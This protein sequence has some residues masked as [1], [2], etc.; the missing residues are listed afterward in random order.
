ME[1]KPKKHSVLRDIVACI[2]P[3]VSLAAAVGIAVL[4]FRRVD[5]S[6]TTAQAAL[7]EA[8][9]SEGQVVEQ[10]AVY[11]GVEDPWIAA[12]SFTVGDEELDAYIRDFCKECSP[13]GATA[14][15]AAQETFNVIVDSTYLYRIDKPMGLD[16][17]ARSAKEYFTS[18][19]GMGGHQGDV[20]EYASVLALCLRYFGY[21]DAIAVPTVNTSGV[22][23]ADGSALCLVTNTDGTGC[24]C[25]PA[26]GSAGWMLPRTSYDILVDDI[27][28]NKDA[29][30]AMGLQIK[31]KYA[32]DEDG[33]MN[34]MDDDGTMGGTGTTGTYG[35]MSG[36][37]T[38]ESNAYDS[39]DSTSSYGD[40]GGDASSLGGSDSYGTTGN[41]G[42]SNSYGNS[43]GYGNS[44]GYGNSNS[45]G[46]DDSYDTYG[47]SGS[48]Y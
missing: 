9:Q 32:D 24:V 40:Y 42:N 17:V 18:D 5:N 37:G 39:S 19:D 25:D 45:Y 28:Q 11:A 4:V 35:G 44:S 13:A 20:Y 8:E 26:V 14:E 31:E 34:G 16:W 36:S 30:L 29:A 7:V 33:S 10:Q 47:T 46:S 6:V 1:E 2:L 15:E 38:S 27:G 21:S 23:D 48:T 12:G 3:I 22:G 41:Y 43:N